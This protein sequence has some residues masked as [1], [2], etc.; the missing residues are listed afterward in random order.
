MGL[1]EVG[2]H[3]VG[4]EAEV[5]RLGWVLRVDEEVTVLVVFVAGGGVD[6]GEFLGSWVSC[7]E[8][9]FHLLVYLPLPA[10]FRKFFAP[11]PADL[12]NTGE[13]LRAH[14]DLLGHEICIINRNLKFFSSLIGYGMLVDAPEMNAFVTWPSLLSESF[15]M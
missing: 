12:S 5:A 13:S 14:V 7:N 8:D 6:S 10:I 2:T 1:R 9:G 4:E 15:K 11:G 3:R